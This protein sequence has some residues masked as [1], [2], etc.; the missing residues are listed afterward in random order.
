MSFM[1]NSDSTGVDAGDPLI[2]GAKKYSTGKTWLTVTTPADPVTQ[3]FKLVISTNDYSIA[4]TYT[5][6]LVVSFVNDKWT[7]TLT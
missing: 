4:S 5:I 6:N 7:G 2:C 1:M 3:Q